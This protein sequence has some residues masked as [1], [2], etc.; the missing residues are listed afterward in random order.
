MSGPSTMASCRSW[1]SMLAVTPSWLTVVGMRTSP[2]IGT[3]I[4]WRGASVSRLTRAWTESRTRRLVVSL[5]VAEDSLKTAFVRVSSSVAS[6][7][8]WSKRWS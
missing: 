2:E 5:S 6:A 7:L 8:N 4:A 3:R 1:G